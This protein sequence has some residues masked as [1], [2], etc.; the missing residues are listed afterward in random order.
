MTTPR[1]EE[2]RAVVRRKAR[3]PMTVRTEHDRRAHGP[4]G[5]RHEALACKRVTSTKEHAIAGPEP[6]TVDARDCTPWV[7]RRAARGSIVAGGADVE[8]ATG[9][10]RAVGSTC[11][12]GISGGNRDRSGE[13][14]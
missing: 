7:V 2:D 6:R 4:G 14:R 11:D 10:R 13:N 12:R 3:S 9:R 8:R 1:G 5:R